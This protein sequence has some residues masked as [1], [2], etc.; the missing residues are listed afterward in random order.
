MKASAAITVSIQQVCTSAT[1][2][3]EDDS[4]LPSNKTADMDMFVTGKVTR[5]G[6]EH[7]AQCE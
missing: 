4:L 7:H 5:C 6:V 2:C 3:S 1:E